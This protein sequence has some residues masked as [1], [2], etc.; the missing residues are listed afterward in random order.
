MSVPD[1]GQSVAASARPRDRPLRWPW[2]MAR[3]VGALALVSVGAIHLQQ[4]FK[5]YSSVPTIGT[6]FV[7]NFVGA[8]FLGLALLVPV[9]R[10]VRA[11]GGALLAL[12][13]LGGVALAAGT[14]VLLTISENTPVFGFVEPGYDPA[15]ITAS[16]VAE[17]TTVALLGAYFIGRFVMTPSAREDR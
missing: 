15:A 1:A 6:L 4:Y 14:L 5:F 11:W 9:E 17:L 7:L 13:T 8:S 16:R 3:Y 12:V 10:I 2:L